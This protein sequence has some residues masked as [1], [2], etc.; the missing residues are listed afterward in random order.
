M[1][2][3]HIINIAL[4]LALI[5]LSLNVYP[6][7][8]DRIPLHFDARGEPDRWGEPSLLSWLTL[9]LIGVG[10]VVFL[11]ITAAVVPRYPKS[12]NVP[13]KKRFMELPAH[14]QQW[15]MR[16]IL[17]VMHVLSTTM[18]LT[19]C[20]LQYGAW[21]AAHS[22]TA[23]GTITAAIVFSLVS[24]PFVTIAFFAVSQR[25]MDAAWRAFRDNGEEAAVPA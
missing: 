11:Y 22:G 5:A 21:E 23:S 12:F 24:T 20:A 9:P 7:L 17:N 2:L 18:L 4:C 16:G 6:D 19:F 15:V 3:I 8:P 1:R 13:D 25:R 10:T 14:L